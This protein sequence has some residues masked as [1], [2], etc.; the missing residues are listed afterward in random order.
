MKFSLEAETILVIS[1]TDEKKRQIVWGFLK[2]EK[3][4]NDT[5]HF[6]CILC[7]NF[8]LML[9]PA[10]SCLLYCH[11]VTFQWL[12][13]PALPVCSI[14]S[15][16]KHPIITYVHFSVLLSATHCCLPK[17]LVLILFQS[18]I[19]QGHVGAHTWQSFALVNSRKQNLSKQTA[20]YNMSGFL[21]AVCTVLIWVPSLSLPWSCSPS[22]F[23]DR[24][25]R[26]GEQCAY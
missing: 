25:R 15:G 11:A 9:D 22:V 21:T 5:Q 3:P 20:L 18:V 6:L 23:S 16:F 13:L 14:W 7:T 2:K 19:S 8:P 10:L 12:F 17:S 26:V 1:K 24:Q 4:T